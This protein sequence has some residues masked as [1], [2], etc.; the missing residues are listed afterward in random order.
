MLITAGWWRM[1]GLAARVQAELVG[2]FASLWHDRHETRPAPDCRSGRGHW[3]APTGRLR[4]ALVHLRHGVT[5]DVDRHE[6]RVQD[7]EMPD[8]REIQ[9]GVDP[10][11]QKVVPATRGNAAGTTQSSVARDPI[12]YSQLSGSSCCRPS[13]QRYL[14]TR[15]WPRGTP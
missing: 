8:R 1:T 10:D 7:A 13:R 6:V 2:E 12:I 9:A 15:R 14:S 5:H 11:M 4:A 3:H